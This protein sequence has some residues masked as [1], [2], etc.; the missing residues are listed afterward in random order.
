MKS[1][2][3]QGKSNI[4]AIVCVRNE[5]R[6][7]DGLITH[8]RDQGVDIAFIDND[9][10]DGSREIIDSHL[11]TNV[12]SVHNL[13]YHGT[14]SLSGQ[15]QAKAEIEQGLTHDWVMHIDA[16]EI[17]H[18]STDGLRLTDVARHA[19]VAG[20]NAVNFEEFVFLPPVGQDLTYKNAHLDI[21]LYY[22]F[23]PQFHRLVRLYRRAQG[24]DNRSG[25]G[26]RLKGNP[27]IYP[28]N[29]VLRHYIG[30]DQ[31]HLLEKYIDRTFDDAE[32]KKG[33]HSNRVGLTNEMLNLERFDPEMFDFL[34]T[35]ASRSF[36]RNRPRRQHFWNWGEKDR[37]YDELIQAERLQSKK[38]PIEA[39][40]IL[41]PPATDRLALEQSAKKI[42]EL[43][44]EVVAVKQRQKQ[45]RIILRSQI[46][47]LKLRHQ[48]KKREIDVL[49]KSA[50]WRLTAPL[51]KLMSFLKY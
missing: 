36:L 21:K 1:F 35:A 39:R 3:Q 12:L 2:E 4:C 8:L 31:T 48:E 23:A 50:S 47:E 18:P 5:R 44:A 19:D 11:G 29:Q 33:W 15:L 42:K 32:L 17:L 16:D 24:L 51:R 43:E 41:A 45:R 22:Y 34:P 20:F 27:I 46:E 38:H 14:F 37:S 49:R 6:Y 25:G 40:K 7:L 9:S 10:T 26:H 30:L 13:S 28:Q